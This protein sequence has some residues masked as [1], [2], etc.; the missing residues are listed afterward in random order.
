MRTALLHKQAQQQTSSIICSYCCTESNLPVTNRLCANTAV[1]GKSALSGHDAECRA[2]A[3][4]SAKIYVSHFFI[5]DTASGVTSPYG[6][7]GPTNY[8][9]AVV[10]TLLETM[11]DLRHTS[12]Q[13]DMFSTIAYIQ[14]LMMCLSDIYGLR[15]IHEYD[16][17]SSLGVGPVH[18]VFL[19]LAQRPLG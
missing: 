8:Y 17:I 3:S 11:H 10:L 4:W 9:S 19:P 16:H 14:W 15:S 6:G 2:E 13:D 5:P 7:D 1:S 18:G 12:T